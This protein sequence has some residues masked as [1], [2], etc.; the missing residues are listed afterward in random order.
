MTI[1]SFALKARE[2]ANLPSVRRAAWLVAAAVFIGGLALSVRARPALIANIDWRL[3]GVLVFILCPLIIAV[4]TVIFRISANIAGAVFQWREVLRLSVLSSALNHLPIP[5]GVILRVGAM[6]SR[7]ANLVDSGAVNLGAALLWLGL[8][9]VFAGAW[10]MSHRVSFGVISSGIGLVALGAGGFAIFR[11][12]HK[13][14]DVVDLLAATAALPVIYSFALWL[15]FRALGEAV[16]FSHAA[17]ISGAGVIGSAAS[18]LPAGLGARE[19]AGAFLAS[20]I[21]VD[22][23]AGFAATAFVHIAMMCAL[24]ISALYFSTKANSVA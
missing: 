20:L 9:F 8:S 7:G 21:S 18:F 22:A 19:A 3:F 13:A 24:A 12:R 10:G 17:V 6:K 1:R 2:V 15:G 4:N 16:G 5:G 23:Y 11:I 14:R